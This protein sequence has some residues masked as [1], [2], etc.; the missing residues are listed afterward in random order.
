MVE[1]VP[2]AIDQ[3]RLR[4]QIIAT[5]MAN[6]VINRMGVVAPFELAEEAGVSLAH[7]AAAYF[8]ADAIFDLEALWTQI[9]RAS[10]SEDARLQLLD[11]TVGSVRV[12]LADLIRASTIEMNAGAIA[13][14]LGEGVRRLDAAAEQLLR[15]EARTQA[16]ALRDRLTAAGA[17]PAL[18][19]RIV[20]LDELD[21]AVGTAELARKL[22]VGEVA[23]TAGYVRLGEALGLDWAKSAAARFVS[24]DPWE[25][26]LTAGLARDFEQLRLDFL[27][28]AAGPDPLAAADTWLDAQRPRVTQF[29][30]LVDR[31][32]IAPVPTAA[33]LAQ[34]AGQARVLLGR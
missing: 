26:L 4:P 6:R 3:H 17:D 8:A 20:R 31:A 19:A 30:G 1:R 10:V 29:R 33:M 14:R 25:R 16:D 18:I 23:A 13:E 7:V 34:I 22:N 15:Q 21:G 5:K 11:S 27:A 24:S 32:R 9:E 28:R 12:H 2:A